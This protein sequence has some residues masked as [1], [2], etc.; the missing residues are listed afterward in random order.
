MRNI[1][2]SNTVL[3]HL[4]KNNILKQCLGAGAWSRVFIQ[5]AEDG[6]KNIGNQSRSWLT[7]LE[8]AGPI[9]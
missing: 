6:K 4:T 3:Y 8:G 2:G 1:S 5:G 9:A 7:Y